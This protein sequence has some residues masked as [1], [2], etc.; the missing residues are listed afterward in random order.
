MSHA[1]VFMSNIPEA[2]PNKQI[3]NKFIDNVNVSL[4]NSLADLE[5][6]HYISEIDIFCEKNKNCCLS[7]WNI[8][9]MSSCNVRFMHLNFSSLNCKQF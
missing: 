6:L 2:R 7:Q 9:R 3:N 5:T 1:F 8:S 4:P